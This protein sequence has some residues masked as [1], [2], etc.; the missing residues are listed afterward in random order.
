MALSVVMCPRE[1]YPVP[2]FGFVQ[3]NAPRMKKSLS[4]LVVLVVIG[5]SFRGEIHAQDAAYLTVNDVYADEIDGSQRVRVY[6]TLRDEFY[7]AIDDPTV[8]DVR[9]SY[10]RPPNSFPTTMISGS[11]VPPVAPTINLMMD[12]SENALPLYI[13]SS[14]DGLTALNNVLGAL[15]SDSRVNLYTYAADHELA[16]ANVTINDVLDYLPDDA[17]GE[18]GCLYDSLVLGA[19]DYLSNFGDVE[20][21][22]VILVTDGNPSTGCNINSPDEVIVSLGGV[23]IPVYIVGFLSDEFS[24]ND[25]VLLART[26]GGSVV[27]GTADELA[28]MTDW[29]EQFGIGFQESFEFNL[30]ELPGD[31]DGSLSV[32]V[33]GENLEVD[34]PFGFTLTSSCDGAGGQQGQ[35]QQADPTPTLPAPPTVTFARVVYNI[36]AQHLE[37]EYLLDGDISGLRRELLVYSHPDQVQIYTTG[38][39]NVPSDGTFSWT[40]SL[41]EF[42]NPNVDEVFVKYR[43][44][45]ANGN[46][47]AE[48]DSNVVTITPSPSV[49]ITS[50]TVDPSELLIELAYTLDSDIDGFFGEVRLFDGGAGEQIYTSGKSPI[51]SNVEQRHSIHFDQLSTT[52]VDNVLAQVIVYDE[53]DTAVMRVESDVLPLLKTAAEL[54]VTATAAAATGDVPIDTPD[55]DGSEPS[56]LTA[57]LIGGGVILALMV[58]FLFVLNKRVRDQRQTQAQ[59]VDASDPR[60]RSRLGKIAPQMPPPQFI[61]SEAVT[62]APAPPVSSEPKPI[63]AFVSYRRTSSAILATY[64][65]SQLGGK[66]IE[67]FVDTR[68]SDGAGPFPERL[69]RAIEDS[70]VFICLLGASAAGATLDS[71]WVLRE[72]EHAHTLGKPMIPVF[73]E[74][75][76]PAE[77]AN[78]H[79]GA[80]L[81]NQGVHIFDVKNIYV[82]A[83]VSELVALVESVK[84]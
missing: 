1:C 51:I 43:L 71:P 31:F 49:T 7:R 21:D 60:S 54:I 58:V 65:A 68:R 23:P 17:S 27:F 55:T 14:T 5:T 69:L 56:P 20:R 39:N 62:P 28:A 12:W 74:S 16:A 83:A 75:Y 61:P 84:R 2:R 25:T 64:L 30:C 44:T 72:I 18:N 36:Y 11:Y 6:F 29:R 10:V 4:L 40:V 24:R 50:F 52:D 53:G 33:N 26:L 19:L 66:G 8:G 22:A 59:V 76:V 67:A 79:I 41:S 34:L 80:L 32:E 9:L 13:N 57:V 48:Q 45:D 47:V 73:Q 63:K 46:I 42:D 82:D 35:S 15:P 3:M 81:Q 38:V 78:E 77:P 70:D 37:I